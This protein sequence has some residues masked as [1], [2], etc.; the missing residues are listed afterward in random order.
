MEKKF[1]NGEI[2]WDEYNQCYGVV[3]NNYG[4]DGG[5]EI[6]LDSDGNQPIKN[7]HKLGSNGDTGTKTQ[8]ISCL[9][10]H[11]SLMDGFPEHNYSPVNY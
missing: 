4:N 8:L 5:G 3:L 2:V 7:L 6:R 9:F 11:K 1:E 10:S